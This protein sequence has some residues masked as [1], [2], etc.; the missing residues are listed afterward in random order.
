M[1]A[2]AHLVGSSMRDTPAAGAA[3]AHRSPA[4]RG[5][6]RA[7]SRDGSAPG[8]GPGGPPFAVVLQGQRRDEVDARLLEHEAEVRE[9]RTELDEAR[10]RARALAEHSA[11]LEA[12][13]ARSSGCTILLPVQGRG[14]RRRPGRV[15]P[16]AR[17]PAP[18]APRSGG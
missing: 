4:R 11:Y 9:L 17:T 13:L 2:G 16:P 18:D 10:R 12:G 14:E 5:P 6:A 7:G 1:A 8:R 15:P 3:E